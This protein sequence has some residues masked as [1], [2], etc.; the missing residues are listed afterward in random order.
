MMYKA[1][2][3]DSTQLTSSENGT[4]TSA[5][6]IRNFVGY[7]FHI[8]VTDATDT[9]G[10]PT[11]KLQG[12]NIGDSDAKHW[13]DLSGTSTNITA[14]GAILINRDADH[15][16]YVRAVFNTSGTDDITATV[17]FTGREEARA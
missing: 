3:L 10:P 1:R 6:N 2:V 16:K 12:S 7:C 17:L 9:S 5:Q 11:V 14:T 15:F 13:Q 8:D 4:T